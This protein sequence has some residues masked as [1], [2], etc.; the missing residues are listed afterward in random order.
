MKPRY[1]KKINALKFII[2]AIVV[3]AVLFSSCKKSPAVK[4]E[5][6]ENG[7]EMPVPPEVSSKFFNP[8]ENANSAYD[9][10]LRAFLVKQDGQTFI[11]DGLNKRDRAYFW[12]QAFMITSLEDAYERT[13]SPERKKL[14]NDLLTSFLIKETSD[15]SWNS[16]TDDIAW[17]TI[18][19]IRGYQ[20]TGNTALRDAAINNWNFAFDR[21]WDSSLGGGL[22]ENMEKHT[23]ASLANNPMIIS[24]T[25]IYEVTGDVKYLNKCKQIMAWV[26]SSGIYD[27]TTGVVNEA[28]VN[29][30]SIQFSDNSYNTGS[31]INAATALFKHTKDAQ[32]L[33]DA[34]RSADHVVNKFGV[35]NQEADA[36][37][38]G[39][40]KLARENNMTDKYY[41]WLVRQCIASWNNRR[42]Y[43]N[44]NNNDWRNQTGPGD[45]LAMQCISA[46]TV[47]AVTPETEIITI[48]NGTYKIIARHNDEALTAAGT[49]N[50]TA[51]ETATYTGS[52]N[53]QW[54]VT[55][56]GEGLYKIIGVGSKRSL[57]ITGNS[58]DSDAP[59]IL[60][61]FKDEGNEK[62]Y[63]SS[64][65][66]GYYSICFVNSGKVADVGNGKGSNIIQQAN[67]G[68]DHQQ[69]QFL[70]P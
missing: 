69:W 24:G 36:C 27:A 21:G 20:I 48:P 23:K 70:K 38:R 29:D 46:V 2:N 33:E 10:F 50:N 43:S 58:G 17:A 39:I 68:S 45:Q 59:I 63:F 47:Q 55:G 5:T 61:D 31:F 60:W 12:G 8:I 40:A 18:A 42:P 53:Q 56:L 14:I 25:F 15:W 3:T 16:W 34:I 67:N 6:N 11:V 66:S 32:Y 26:K 62:V 44:I 51:L 49:S 19:C 54:V 64:S 30:G 35:M 65:E 7:G 13:K 9:G 52:D 41:P 4:T 1:F 22:W 37:V 28:K 57:N